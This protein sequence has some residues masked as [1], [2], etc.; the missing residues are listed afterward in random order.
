MNNP[1]QIK[2]RE[3]MS[4]AITQITHYHNW[5]FNSFKNFITNGIVLEV[6]SGHG[7]YS[8]KIAKLVH[9]LIVSDIDVGAIEIIKE[10]LKSINNID[11]VVMDGV[12]NSKLP[13]QIDT[14]I[15]IN[16]IEHIK[17]D[18]TFIKS[19]Y[20][21]LKLNGR[22]II[23]APA[24]QMLFSNYDRQAGHY[25]RYTKSQFR[26]LLQNHFTIEKMHYFNKI[27]FWGWLVNKYSKSHINSK[28]TH[29]QI[30]LYDKLIPFLKYFDY[31]IPFIGQSVI[32][33]ATKKT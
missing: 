32:V 2:S 26:I 31:L 4:N 21:I 15:A 13:F 20:E 33:I 8:K 25:R 28:S 17:N 22:L 5:V 27:G 14:I 29:S 1:S 9:K 10:H 3:T 24:F 7:I 23:F 16:I 11:Y 18:D 12:D 19:C 6:G 30:K